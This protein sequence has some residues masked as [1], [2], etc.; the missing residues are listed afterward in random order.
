[1]GLSAS[2]PSS[3]RSLLVMSRTGA[4]V[5]QH[6]AR[7]DRKLGHRSVNVAAIGPQG[8]FGGEG[9]SGL[10][11]SSATRDKCSTRA[12]GRD[13]NTSAWLSAKP[14]QWLSG[15]ISR[16]P[17]AGRKQ[18]PAS[19]RSMNEELRW[20]PMAS[21]DLDRE[22]PPHLRISGFGPAP[23]GTAGPKPHGPGCKRRRDV[24]PVVHLVSAPACGGN[25]KNP[26]NPVRRATNAVPGVTPPSLQAAAPWSAP[27]ASPDSS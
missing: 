11:S 22:Q 3:V 13:C 23:P 2:S 24:G 19:G 7:V 17:A 1:M 20:Q 8:E 4:A 16:T 25:A 27:P 6:P 14:D 9:R 10:G 26:S 5:G 12:D 18:P 15:Q 21:R